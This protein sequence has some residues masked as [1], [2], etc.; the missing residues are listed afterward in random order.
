MSPLSP[1]P[2]LG[3]TPCPYGPCAMSYA[4]P[5]CTNTMPYAVIPCFGLR[6]LGPMLCSYAM[7]DAIPL[8]HTHCMGLRE[9]P[10]VMPDVNAPVYCRTISPYSIPLRFTLHSAF[11]L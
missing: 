8:C 7:P 11:P 6:P 5:L 2:P 9:C 4:M 3:P 1:L 10:F